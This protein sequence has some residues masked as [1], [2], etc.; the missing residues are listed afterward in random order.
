[1]IGR[2]LAFVATC[3]LLHA[4][5]STYEHLSILK[6]MGKPENHIPT[7]IILEAV[8]SFFIFVPGVVLA[9]GPLED[10]TWRGEMARRSQEDVHSRMS[11]LPFGPAAPKP[12]R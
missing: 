3:L 11:F 1:M 6:A 8:L 7:S 12:V 10:V 4:A 5:Y 9:S 2:I